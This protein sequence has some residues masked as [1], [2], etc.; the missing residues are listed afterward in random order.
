M[1][2]QYERTDSPDSA[3]PCSYTDYDVSTANYEEKG[4][5]EGDVPATGENATGLERNVWEA[6]YRIEDPEMPISIVDLGLV[7]G[8]E[9]D[10]NTG[11]VDVEMT[12]TYT[13]C[14]ARDMLLN[15]VEQRLSAVDGVERADI[16]LVWSPGWT[17]DM[18]TDEGEQALRDFGLSV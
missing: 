17:V 6:L 8:V 3:T 5:A 16:T 9:A 2:D 4:S 15:E 13:G 12:L 10:E 1:T 14:P 18:V 7:Y 11:V